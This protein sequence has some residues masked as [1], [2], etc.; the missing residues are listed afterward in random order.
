MERIADQNPFFQIS[1]DVGELADS[2]IA[3]LFI[4]VFQ[5]VSVS[6]VGGLREF[7]GD[8]VGI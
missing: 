8:D 3:S 1:N 2:D 4:S 5:R 7:S 6:A